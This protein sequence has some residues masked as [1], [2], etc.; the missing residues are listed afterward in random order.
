MASKSAVAGTFQTRGDDFIQFV[1]NKG[2][3][4]ASIDSN[5]QLHIAGVYFADGTYQNSAPSVTSSVINGGTF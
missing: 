1:D 5:G 4:V 3:L 2:S